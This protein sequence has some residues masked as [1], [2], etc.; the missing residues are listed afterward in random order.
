M[1]LDA[2]LV[3]VGGG[4]ANGL[5]AWRL[6]QARPELRLLLLEAGATLGGNHTWSFHDADLDPAQHAWL[7]PLVACRWE[8]H[9]VRFPAFTRQMRGGYASITSSRLHDLMA[10]QLAPFVRLQTAVAA[11]APTRVTLRDGSVLTAGAVLDGRGLPPAHGLR[12]GWQKFIGHEIELARPHGLSG[13][14]LMDATVPQRGGYRFVYTLPLAARRV[15]VEDTFYADDQRLDDAQVRADIAAYVAA[16]GW[17]AERLVREEQGVLPIVLEGDPAAWWDDGSRVARTG[18]SA[19]LFHPT[20]GYSL[21][22]AVRLADVIAA[23]PD[24]RADALFDA[25]RAHALDRWRAQGFYRL[26]NRMFFEAAPP[27]ERWRVMQQFYRRPE[28]L[29]ERFYAGRLTVLDQLRIVSGK[30]P[31]PLRAAF[32]A[33]VGRPATSWRFS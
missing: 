33:A 17:R 5:I 1:R 29:I 21:A 12:L 8:G 26:L 7:A 10:A 23:Q 13:P 15:L 14:I 6:S 28:P 25:V 30:P 19:A 27:Q 3:L 9:G 16:Q 20:T 24:L 32:K 4:L 18:L 31:V 22:E 11:V 2:D